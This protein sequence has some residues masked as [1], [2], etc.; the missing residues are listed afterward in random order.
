[1]DTTQPTAD[2][3]PLPQIH[4]NHELESRSV[5]AF[6]SL[7]QETMVFRP[8][9][10][11]D[12][13]VDG[14]LEVKL[15]GAAT[16]LRAKVQL[17]A[18]SS[19]TANGDGSASY[20][21]KTSNLNYLLN[22]PSPIYILYDDTT[23][24]L[25]YAWAYDEQR[26][27]AEEN[28]DWQE[29]E[30]ITLKFTRR[31]SALNHQDIRD[32]ILGEARML[33]RMNETLA[34]AAI[35]EPMTIFAIESGSLQVTDGPSATNILTNE[36]LA[37]ASAGYPEAVIRLTW[38]V[39]ANTRAHPRIQLVAGYAEY[40]LGRYF[41]A[42]GHLRQ[43]LAKVHE[44]AERD[45]H[46]LDRVKD[47]CEFGLGIMS[48]AV[49]QERLLLHS[50]RLKGVAALQ[51]DLQSIEYNILREARPEARAALLRDLRGI[52]D[53]IYKSQGAATATR[54]HAKLVLLQAEGNEIVRDITIE[55]GRIRM[56]AAN[57]SPLL[58]RLQENLS[59]QA[60]A[61]ISEWNR[62]TDETFMASINPSHPILSAGV[63]RAKLN[64]AVFFMVNAV[65]QSLTE[66][67][68]PA[69]QIPETTVAQ[70]LSSLDH[71]A[72]LYENCGIA[73]G[74]LGMMILK[75]NFLEAVGRGEQARIVAASAAAE[76]DALQ[77]TDVADAAR[78]LLANETVFAKAVRAST[79]LSKID[80][81]AAYAKL[82]DLEIS[83]FAK[84]IH[85]SQGLPKSDLNLVERDC[86]HAREF[87]LE[88]IHHCRHL[89]FL[90][91]HDHPQTSDLAPTLFPNW[92]Y[93]CKKN[94]H[95]ML[96]STSDGPALI[97][98][99]KRQFC[100]NC[101]DRSPKVTGELPPP[102]DPTSI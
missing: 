43:A 76:A 57:R 56:A 20:P 79:E 30:T 12:Y 64:F 8:E 62:Q 67:G 85:E 35:N 100:T 58:S 31:L 9:S 74:R 40:L 99:F 83:E 96:R 15:N 5:T 26:R 2:L 53:A 78:E 24:E 91:G 38:M 95:F 84:R 27:L 86:L 10:H 13:G 94:K 48:A 49:Y 1:M 101:P 65:V 25:W 60:K 21:I 42:I 77:H 75:A 6:S 98:A 3:G 92:E 28:P 63:L 102:G 14:E 46:F 66:N 29:Q 93:N 61:R 44:L 22:G 54:L 59:S 39:D 7:V 87:C 69:L 34:R 19:V 90:A 23:K 36:G 16:N 89:E 88:Q 68:V 11:R 50:K 72:G 55:L 51:A 47:T 97:S 32:R 18:A 41:N 45:Q 17:K 80:H 70:T 37:L 82:T 71:A 73:P 4:P 81:A 52:V 33:R